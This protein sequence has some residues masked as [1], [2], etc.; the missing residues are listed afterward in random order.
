MKVFKKILKEEKNIDN[1]KI[2]K[3]VVDEL[4]N[5]HKYPTELKTIELN[6]IQKKDKKNNIISF[7]GIKKI[8]PKYLI[9]SVL[10]EVDIHN[11][12][13]IK[14]RTTLHFIDGDEKTVIKRFKWDGKKLH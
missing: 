2:V 4:V 8:N 10:L 3:K 6:E 14:V 5:I 13:D 12:A 9:R 7:G 11:T 1:E